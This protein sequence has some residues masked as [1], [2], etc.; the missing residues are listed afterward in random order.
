MEPENTQAL[1]FRQA[2]ALMTPNKKD[3]PDLDD[4]FTES[5]VLTEAEE[6]NPTS[7]SIANALNDNLT[8]I[9]GSS[10]LQTIT[11]PDPCTPIDV[12]AILHTPAMVESAQTN[13]VDTPSTP[14]RRT[15]ARKTKLFSTAKKKRKHDVS[16]SSDDDDDDSD[17]QRSTATKKKQKKQAKYVSR[18]E[19]AVPTKKKKNRQVLDIEPRGH[20][21]N[22]NSRLDFSSFMNFMGSIERFRRELF[23][24]GASM[25]INDM[26]QTFP[27]VMN[28]VYDLF[29]STVRKQPGRRPS[30]YSGEVVIA[31]PVEFPDRG[32]QMTTTTLTMSAMHEEEPTTPDRSASSVPSSPIGGINLFPYT[33]PISEGIDW[34]GLGLL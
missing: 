12:R 6:E 2:L 18:R 34:S 13:R 19:F 24:N 7:T 27:I 1:T 23:V 17:V 33:S 21:N 16:S 20:L 10:H 4:V 8:N 26:S 30:T 22:M 11:H 25:G 31:T 28:H 9:G 14:I 29:R 15:T 5:V 3:G 32:H